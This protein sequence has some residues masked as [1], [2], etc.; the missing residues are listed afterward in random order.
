MDLMKL[1]FKNINVRFSNILNRFFNVNSNNSNSFNKTEHHHYGKSP[2]E[3]YDELVLYY[4]QSIK[5]GIIEHME[6]NFRM[7]EDHFN[8]NQDK[9]SR[10]KQKDHH[11]LAYEHY[12]A[13]IPKLLERDK[14][15][16]H[17][18]EKKEYHKLKL[19]N[20]ATN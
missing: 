10:D 8:A 3:R 17:Y 4:I 11:K 7:L 13:V 18:E 20:H 12:K 2:N 5:S 1:N 6:D 16:S 9:L 19:N 15:V 14:D